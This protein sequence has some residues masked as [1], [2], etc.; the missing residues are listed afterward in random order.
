VAS[1]EIKLANG[2]A[3]SEHSPRRLVQPAD[4]IGLNSYTLKDITLVGFGKA[5]VDREPYRPPQTLHC[6]FTMFPPEL[7]FDYPPSRKLDI[8]QL[9]CLMFKIHTRVFPFQPEHPSYELLVRDIAT[10]LGPIPSRWQ[11]RYRWDRYTTVT[12]ENEAERRDYAAWC[13]K[14]QPMRSLEKILRDEPYPNGPEGRKFVDLLLDMLAW[15]PDHRPTSG[16]VY[17][18]LVH[19]DP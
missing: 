19:I 17:G 5:F 11:G 2:E 8:W 7:L 15:E 14:K 10:Y 13:D 3:P 9:A 12:P 1:E 4:F 6:P 16:M 18:R